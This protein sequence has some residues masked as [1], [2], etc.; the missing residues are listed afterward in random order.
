MLLLR[1]LLL[2]NAGVVA[3]DDD[4]GTLHFMKTMTPCRETVVM[5]THTLIE[6]GT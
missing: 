5:L 6:H 2:S 4:D 1:S 3:A